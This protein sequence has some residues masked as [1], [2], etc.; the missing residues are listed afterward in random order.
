MGNGLSG[1]GKGRASPEVHA[2]WEGRVGSRGPGPLEPTLRFGAPPTP[3]CN[4]LLPFFPPAQVIREKASHI[5]RGYGFVSYA[6]PAYATVAMHHM[7][8][9][10]MYGPF[11][12][13]RLKV[14]AS[15]KRF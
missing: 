6:H 8:G 12:G 15:N 2:A 14:S 3:L 1:R 5:S 11:G 10:M 13:Q 9:Q 7:H 4:H